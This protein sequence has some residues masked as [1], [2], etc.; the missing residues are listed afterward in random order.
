MCTEHQ[1]TDLS[2]ALGS[3]ISSVLPLAPNT[4]MKMLVSVPAY[5]VSPVATV[6]T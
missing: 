3:R 2:P 4:V 1:T 5:W 6:V